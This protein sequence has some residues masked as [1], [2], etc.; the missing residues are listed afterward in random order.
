[1]K[2]QTL[3]KR[4]TRTKGNRPKEIRPLKKQ[5]KNNMKRRKTYRKS[6]GMKGG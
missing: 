6:R 4:R 5:T 3:K 1:M 2:H